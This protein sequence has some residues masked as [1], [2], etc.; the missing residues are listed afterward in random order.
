MSEDHDS[1]VAIVGMAGRLPGA[2]DLGELWRNLRD[3]VESVRFFTDEELRALGVDPRLIADPT[4]VKAA[5]QPPGVDEFDAG[6]FGISHREA[7]ILDPQQRIFLEI[8]WEALEDAGYEPGRLERVTG[9]FAGQ[10][11]STYLLFNLVSNPALLESYDPLSMLV[12]NAGDSL[13]TRVSYKLDLKGPSYT[14]QCAC[15]TSAVAVHAACQSLLNSEC[16]L[17]LAGGVSINTQL[18]TGYRS[19]DGAVFSREGR[20]RAFDAGAQGILFGGGAGVVVLKRLEDALADGDNIHAVILGSAVNNDG[21]LKV[22]YTAPSVEGQAEVISEALSFSGVP[23]ESLSYIEAHGT[24]TRLGD[25]IEIQALTKAFRA[26]T[27]RR[28]FIPIGS[29]K[30]NIGHLDVAAGIAGLLKT[31]L[32]LKHRQIPPTLHFITPNPEI[33]FASS[34]VRVNTEL[35]DWEPS[36][37]SPRRAGVSSFGFGGTNAHLI[38]EEAPEVAASP[39]RQP[40]H[41][42]RLSARSDAALEE[43]SRRLA[44]WLEER[45]ELDLA[46]V[47]FTLQVGRRSFE[48]RRVV[49]ARTREE[50]IERLRTPYPI[51]AALEE[52]SRRWL[53]G[54]NVDSNP[55]EGERRRRVSLP[56]YP[57]E[58]RRYWIDRPGMPVPGAALCA[59]VEP[60]LPLPV[61]EATAILARASGAVRTFHPRPNLFSA[62]APPR[63]EREEKVCRIWQEVLGVEPVGIYD[64][65]FQLGGHSLLATQILSRVRE[66]FG[67]D[68]PLEH[69]FSLPTAADLAEAIGSLQ[70][71][72]SAAPQIPRS[73]L[74]ET[75]GPYALSFPQERLW[76]LESLRPGGAGFNIPM[77]ARLQGALDVRALGASL[78]QV[79]DRHEPLRT[80]FPLVEGRPVQE[81]LPALAV[82]L[83]L[84]DLGSLEDSSREVERLVRAHS[85]RPF[86]LLRGPLIGALLLR[87]GPQDHRLLVT[88]HHTACD[89]WSIGVMQRD[90][91]RVYAALVH[92]QPPSLPILPLQYA[93]F[94]DWQRSRFTGGAVLDEALAFWRPR[95]EGMPYL[96]LRGDRPRPP[97]QSFR[98][99]NEDV[100]LPSDLAHGLEELAHGEGASL[101]MV[102]LA[103]FEL[104]LQRWAQQ[105]DFAVG[106]F[107]ANRNRA[108]V[109]NL[110]GVFINNLPLRADVGGDPTVRELVGRVRATALDAFAHQDLPFEKLLQ[111]LRPDRDASRGAL[112]QTAFNLLNF[113]TVRED[114]PGVTL[115][116]I[117]LRGE[118]A[119]FDLSFWVEAGPGGLSGWLEHNTDLFDSATVQ[120]MAGHLERLLAGMAA[121]PALRVA[122]LPW[123]DESERNQVLLDWNRTE[124]P[125]PETTFTA[126]FRE[127]AA[128]APDAVAAVHGGRRLTYGELSRRSSSWARRLVER[129]VGPDGLVAILAERSLD[130]LT[131]VLAVLEAGGAWLPLDPVQPPRRLLTILRQSGAAL[132]LSGEGRGAQILAME[133]WPGP[134][135]VVLE[136][137]DLDSLASDGSFLPLRSEP[138]HLAYVI[139][140]SGSTG[141]PKGAMVHQRGMLNHLLAKVEDLGLAAADGVAQNASQSFDISVWQ[142]LAALV[143]GGRVHILSDEVA[144]SPEALLGAVDREGITVLEVVPSLLAALLDEMEQGTAPRM[145]A[146]RWLIPTGEA[147]PPDLCRRWLALRPEVPLVN[148]YGPTECSDDVTHHIVRQAPASGAVHVPIGRPIANTRLYVVDPGF[149]PLP[150]GVPGELCVGGMGVGRGYLGDADRTA[151]AFLPDPFAAG[152]SGARLY[153][154]GDLARWLADGIVEFLGRIDHQVKVRGHRIELGEVEAVLARHPGIREVAVLA[155]E[156]KPGDKRLAAYVAPRAG[157]GGLSAGDLRAWLRERLPEPMVPTSYALLE[158]LP[159]TPNGKIDRSALPPPVWGQAEDDAFVAP[160]TPIE[161]R[162]AAVWRELLGL[163]RVGA[164][165]SFFDVGGHSLLATRLAH[166]VRTELQVDLP[167]RSIFEAPVLAEMALVIEELILEDQMRREEESHTPGTEVVQTGPP[168]L[169]RTFEEG[170]GAPLSLQQERLWFLDR[171]EPG[172]AAYHLPTGV[173]LSG[174]LDSASLERC[175]AEVVRRH[176]ALR[177]TFR[178]ST[179]ELRQVVAPPA[180][181]ILRVLDLRG[182]PSAVREQEAARRLREEVRRPLDL[183]HG[184]VF[185][186]LLARLDGREWV[187]L[188]VF[189]HIVSD[190]WSLGVLVREIAALYGAFTAG[191]D[192]PLPELPVQYGDFARWQ[193]EWLQGEVLE[194]LVRHW[195]QE[196]AGAPQVLDLPT[197][198]PRPAVRRS[199]G[200]AGQAVLEPGLANAVAELARARGATPFMVLLAGFQALLH[201]WTGQDDLLVGTPVANRSRP[202]LE[203]L[204]GFFVNT[205]V[206]RGRIRDAG[207]AGFLG[208]LDRTRET[209]VAAYAHQDVPFERLVDELG[210]QRSLAHT[211]LVQVMLALQN[212]PAGPLSLPGLT[213]TP[214]DLDQGTAA[215]DL[216]LELSET[217]AGLVARLEYDTDLFDAATARRLLDHLRVLLGA[218]V[219]DPA[220]RVAHLPLL[221]EAERAQ[222]ATWN[223]TAVPYP[224]AGMCLDELIAAQAE[225][226]PGAEAVRCEDESLTYAELIERTRS[227][228]AHLRTLGVGPE[229]LVGICAERSLEMVVGLLAILTAGGAYVPLDPSYPA[230]RLASILEDAE[231]PVLLTQSHLR[232]LLPARRAAVLDLDA[233]G[234]RVSQEPLDS[235]L[236]DCLAYAIF[237]S[238][239]TGRPKGTLNSHRGVVNR[240]LWMHQTYGLAPDDRVLQKTPFSFDVSVWEL[241]WPLIAGARLVVARPGGHQDPA[242][243]A[244]TIAREGITTVHFVPSMLHTFL[245]EQDLG[246][247]ASLRRVICS[248]EAL[249]LDLVRRFHELVGGPLGAELHNLYG[250]TEA[251]VDVTF[252]ACRPG[253]NRVPIG[254]PVANTAIHLLDREGEPVPVGVPGELHIGGVQVGRGYLRRPDLTAERFVPDPFGTPGARLYRTG[255]LARRLADGEVEFL[256]RLDHQVKIR[257]VRVELGEIEAEL[258]R[259]PA[260][261]Q[262]VVL[263]REL[264]ARDWRLVAYVVPD[265]KPGIAL[266]RDWAGEDWDRLRAFLRERLPEPMVPAAFVALEA[267]PLTPSG[268]ADRRAL[269]DPDWRRASSGEFV[270]PRTELERRLAELWAGILRVDRIGAFDSFFD[271]GGHSLLAN[272][273]VSRC[274]ICFGVELPLRSVFEA[275]VL[276]EMALLIE[277]L[278]LEGLDAKEAGKIGD[279][280]LVEDASGGLGG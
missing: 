47:A 115:H 198:R 260:V 39:S 233:P 109:E 27:D 188:A 121:D 200:D 120:R 142:L 37:G 155:L 45:S 194:G 171:L 232:D 132:L 179:D 1:S 78:Q 264:D 53:A 104:L 152:E 49:L 139:F 96:D 189:H 76:F 63:D 112:V 154:T 201:R 97:V 177:T 261:R 219:A 119:H 31:V 79:V 256:G 84:V 175:L 202:E 18:L 4:Y 149:R 195:R 2:R 6:F 213:L 197:D 176:A 91:S 190:G 131:A 128:R 100:H 257:G 22:G 147:L 223:A 102:L 9:V 114:L 172:S 164:Y 212:A 211:P 221:T 163:E 122:D 67:L 108:E 228:A 241:F 246:R 244:G 50:A 181:W 270:E 16:D 48:R 5:A 98:G 238:G 55:Y 70:D 206:L 184:P 168:P 52:P 253:E 276:A 259:H 271:L 250:P 64:N 103:G 40:W 254:R 150:A 174:D 32:A 42:L 237:T 151:R 258:G 222:L 239:S 65:F 35:R 24:G 99:D 153:R 158:S 107:V 126:L 59:A 135:P 69:L 278:I 77:I 220:R 85:W 34:P 263:A 95:L 62:Y 209:A 92:G 110:V 248:G 207:E 93:D 43:A 204:I 146:L 243:L 265:V 225:R 105:D 138:A 251:A 214:F 10:T 273:L 169:R 71:Q 161:E 33:D 118:R 185:R 196:L 217:S 224:E 74:R 133:E 187:L 20:C 13:A 186:T 180:P 249:P 266:A 86:D 192:S 262:A 56:T 167:V 183:G 268:K 165:D 123:V 162:L 51:E 58:R 231:V 125:R 28:Q 117:G 23:A 130:F 205:L 127:Q 199:R 57:F 160:G 25:P 7:E 111:E 8:C 54:E 227:L 210:V 141:L 226:T 208:L 11:T 279:Q 41:A 60:P 72:G 94:A 182:L 144:H 3:G 12:G 143:A 124:R 61:P 269:P 137:G 166:R 159:L 157:S 215:F 106:A 267:F 216:N 29:V 235:R 46:D 277:E 173:R 38:L 240:L 242:Y 236:P 21:A 88:V 255:D 73:P 136:I 66:V 191:E 15:S 14:I 229:V 280:S 80:R 178:E 129:G 36:E 247:C 89:G 116:G 156:V 245:E 82:P 101:F 148:A 75:G 134:G 68:F 275:P 170:S 252:H 218:A 17:A 26:E 30:T 44:G 81:V 87:T 234:I 140:T 272:Q 193:R 19:P 145:D 274:R 230:E 90:L 203:G 83:P 113:P